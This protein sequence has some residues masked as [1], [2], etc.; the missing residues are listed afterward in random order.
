MARGSFL[1]LAIAAMVSVTAVPAMAQAPAPAAINGPVYQI[2]FFEV[3]P[4]AADKAAPL[5]GQYAAES[6]KPDGNS[7]ALVARETARPG[8]FALIEVWR[9]KLAAEAHAA[10]LAAL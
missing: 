9:D 5:L 1:G 6:R 7:G 8:R 2:S 3:V 10:A 4:G